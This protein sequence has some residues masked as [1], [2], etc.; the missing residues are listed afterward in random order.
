MYCIECKVKM[1]LKSD[2]VT[3]V[4]VLYNQM[5]YEQKELYQCPKCKNIEV[6]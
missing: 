5:D 3:N 6:D 1:V 4:T 2:I